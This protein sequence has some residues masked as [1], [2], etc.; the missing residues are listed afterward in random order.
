VIIVVIIVIIIIFIIRLLIIIIIIS[1]CC[2]DYHIIIQLFVSYNHHHYCVGLR[3][4]QCFF[5]SRLY[6]INSAL[7]ELMSGLFSAS[8]SRDRGQS[9]E[10]DE[11]Y[12][13]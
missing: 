6:E 5:T 11:A 7:Q 3:C 2:F 8:H 12:Y 9:K 10:S 1:Y 13:Y 4:Y